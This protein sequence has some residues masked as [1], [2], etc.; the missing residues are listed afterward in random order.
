MVGVN[1]AIPVPLPFGFS[2]TGWK[3][4]FYGDLSVYGKMGTMFYTREK[5]VT[6]RFDDWEAVETG[7]LPGLAGVGVTHD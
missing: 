6:T 2:F 7:V 3:E 5:S 4:S 1:A